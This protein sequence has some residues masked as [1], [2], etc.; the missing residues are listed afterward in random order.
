M[1]KYANNAVV[2]TI[3]DGMTSI[4][5]RTKEVENKLD[6]HIEDE[7]E[8]RTKFNKENKDFKDDIDAKI[9]NFE[10]HINKYRKDTISRL[11][12][13]QGYVT[14]YIETDR[15]ILSN[16]IKKQ[17]IAIAVLS[18]LNLISIGLNIFL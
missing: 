5:D 13:I 6:K 18:V 4:A 14:G 7:D 16:Y 12:Y 10:D 17:N 1:A 11:D 15:A 3:T 9:M 8:F 2:S